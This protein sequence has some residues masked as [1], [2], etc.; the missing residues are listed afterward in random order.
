MSEITFYLRDPKVEK[1][2]IYISDWNKKKLVK[3]EPDT[4]V[5]SSPTTVMATGGAEMPF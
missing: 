3:P 4:A 2:T 1:T 5:A